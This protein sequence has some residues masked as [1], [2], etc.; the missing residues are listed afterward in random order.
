[1]WSFSVLICSLASLENEGFSGLQ[2]IKVQKFAEKGELEKLA[3]KSVSKIG[4]PLL[5]VVARA[6]LRRN[7]SQRP[8]MRK[9]VKVLSSENLTPEVLGLLGPEEELVE[10]L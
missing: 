1:M 4:N 3:D 9:I 5:R 7:P 10:D 8:D 6:C 2:A